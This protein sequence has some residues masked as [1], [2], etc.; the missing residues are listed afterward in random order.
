MRKLAPILLFFGP[1]TVQAQAPES[2]NLWNVPFSTLARPAA[3]AR[4]VTGSFWNPAGQPGRS[5]LATAAQFFQ[6]PD[7]IGL[8]GVLA[9][10]SFGLTRVINLGLLAGRM[11]VRDLVRTST[12][13]LIE[14][15]DIPVYEQFLGLRAGVTFAGISGSASISVHDSRFD[16]DEDGGV[17]ADFGVRA[18]LTPR[19]M[20]A[21][22][23]HFLPVD[24]SRS[25][26]TFYYTGI[27]YALLDSDISGTPARILGR[28]GANYRTD[29][30]W[31][32]HLGVGFELVRTFSF[33]L[34]LVRE[35]GFGEGNWRPVLGMELQVGR[36]GIQVARGSGINDIGAI[37][38]VGLE[39][40]IVP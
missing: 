17:T 19:L 39:V 4:G 27:E 9:G 5:R 29:F 8:T 38:R 3:L 24:L 30:G 2:A 26:T 36:Y 16:T 25:N 15:G 32:H 35:R 12:T 31:D 37:F 23:T 18:Q 34:G 20:V 28:Y 40:E 1:V 33:D 11:E 22:A 6:T 13:P 21:A 14:Q 7:V 10:A